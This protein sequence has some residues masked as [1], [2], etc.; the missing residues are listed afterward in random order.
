[1]YYSLSLSMCI[2][3]FE[4]RFVGYFYWW[5]FVC[6]LLGT[7]HS[8][9]SFCCMFWERDEWPSL[10]SSGSLSIPSLCSLLTWPPF[11][12]DLSRS[13][14]LLMLF[15]SLS[16]PSFSLLIHHSHFTSYFF[17]YHDPAWVWYSLHIAIIH[18]IISLICFICL[19]VDTMFTLGT[20]GSTHGF[21]ML[22]KVCCWGNGV[23]DV[24]ILWILNQEDQ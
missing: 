22:V 8:S 11:I 19:L 23:K 16:S 6:E 2:L 15:A 17:S 10:R 21:Q 5:E 4:G 14:L 7:F 18:L 13:S 3:V 20:I 1:M 12:F 24:E 9:Y